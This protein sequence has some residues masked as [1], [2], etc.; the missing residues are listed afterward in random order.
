VDLLWIIEIGDNVEI[1]RNAN[2]KNLSLMVDIHGFS[3]ASEK[4]YELAF[5]CTV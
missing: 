4:A 2:P 1:V 3:D 5:T